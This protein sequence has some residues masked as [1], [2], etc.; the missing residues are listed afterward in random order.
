MK[1]LVHSEIQEYKE[2]EGRKLN[3][4]C[5]KNMKAEKKKYKIDRLKTDNFKALTGH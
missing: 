1:N 2:I 3:I 5:F 4:V